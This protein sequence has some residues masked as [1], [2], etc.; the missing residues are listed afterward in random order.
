[1]LELNAFKSST[2]RSHHQ[3]SSDI[4]NLGGMV[5]C[6]S[7][8]E[9]IFYCVDILRE[10]VEQ[11]LDILAETIFQP[12]F[13]DEEI[14]ESKS[15]ISWASDELPGNT[16]SRD[17]VQ[18]AGYIGSP[19]SNPHYCPNDF[20]GKLNAQMLRDFKSQQYFGN[21]SI[22]A[23]AG[24]EHDT[25][26]KMVES[27]FSGIPQTSS[28]YIPRPPSVYTGGMHLNERE[29]K[30][31]FIRI[32]LAFEC[33]GWMDDSLVPLCVLQTLLGGGSSFSAG[34]LQK[35][36]CLTNFICLIYNEWCCF[37]YFELS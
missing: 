11:G 21:N 6:I 18:I 12:T 4:E 32:C 5:Q 28:L 1:M 35:E 14:E 3:L 15:I 20:I 13:P 30:E 24:I 19:L 8:R 7:T 36:D 23:A 22:I 27:R 17:A 25:L 2:A 16:L 31:P 34:N 29:L 9:N 10:N 26:V 33:G 37:T